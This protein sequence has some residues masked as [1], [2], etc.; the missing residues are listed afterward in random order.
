MPL[1]CIRKRRLKLRQ[2]LGPAHEMLN[3]PILLARILDAH[4]RC[5]SCRLKYRPRIWP[6]RRRSRQKT[7]AEFIEVFR[8][9]RV[10]LPRLQERLWWVLCQNLKTRSHA[11]ELAGECLKKHH[12]H[13]IPVRSFAHL[14]L[15]GLLRSHVIRRAAHHRLAPLP[16][17]KIQLPNQTKV[18]HNHATGTRHQHIARLQIAVQPLGRV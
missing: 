3:I 12:S 18:E 11:W 2:L 5:D 7:P 6:V 13:R 15:E 10:D 16:H 8:Y 17:Q 9:I 4:G 1:L 14:A